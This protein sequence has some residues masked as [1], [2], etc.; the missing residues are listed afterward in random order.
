MVQSTTATSLSI[1]GLLLK[2]HWLLSAGIKSKTESRPGSVRGSPGV[3]VRRNVAC[4]G[5]VEAKV[6]ERIVIIGESLNA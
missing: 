4:T 5:L 1:P 2:V 6:A 3:L